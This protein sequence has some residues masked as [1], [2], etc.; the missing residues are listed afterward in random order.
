MFRCQRGSSWLKGWDG[1]LS[2]FANVVAGTRV[3]GVSPPQSSPTKLGS[4]AQKH[5]H[6]PG[7]KTHLPRCSESTPSRI[8]EPLGSRP[9][10]S[11]LGGSCCSALNP[12]ALKSQV[13]TTPQSLKPH[14]ETLVLSLSYTVVSLSNHLKCPWFRGILRSQFAIS[15]SRGQQIVLR[16]NLLTA[17]IVGVF[18]DFVPAGFLMQVAARRGSPTAQVPGNFVTVRT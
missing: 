17:N 15:G 16:G 3:G 5:S 4:E 12:Q 18:R 7:S 14:P 8:T 10:M 9:C 11:N 13:G 6:D 2:V 1:R